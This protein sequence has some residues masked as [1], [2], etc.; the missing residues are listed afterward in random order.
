MIFLLQY[1][2][3]NGRIDR[4][5]EFPDTEREIAANIRL[6]IELD[7]ARRGIER[8]VLLLE[9]SSMEALRRTH[10][11]FFEDVSEIAST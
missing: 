7:L 3:A 9:A 4:I 11:R 8:D 1:N 6:E 10:R 2:R 5:D